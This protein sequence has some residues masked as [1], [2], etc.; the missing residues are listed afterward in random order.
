LLEKNNPQV[1][2]AADAFQSKQITPSRSVKFPNSGVF[3]TSGN[4]GSNPNNNGDDD[5]NY[6]GMPNFSKVESIEETEKRVQNMD[7]S[8]QR[9]KNRLND[10]SETESASESEEDQCR[11]SYEE[12][13]DLIKK[14][15]VGSLQVTN[16]YKVTA[17]Q[18]LKKAYPFQNTFGINLDNYP[19]LTNE[20][21]VTLFSALY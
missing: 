2:F 14:T 19:T 3:S 7:K 20:D 11:M 16:D 1:I 17:W 12:A 8:L 4:G 13:Y 18:G 9:L 10:E 6:N 21:L 5:R 15:Y